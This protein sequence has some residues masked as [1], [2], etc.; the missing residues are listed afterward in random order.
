[1]VNSNAMTVRIAVI[2]ASALL[3]NCGNSDSPQESSSP[4][5][6][7]A[8]PTMQ[9]PGIEL[10]NGEHDFGTI[11]DL[12]PVSCTVP[13]TNIGSQPLVIRDLKAGCGCTKPVASK[14]IL[15]PGEQ[16]NIM[17]TFDPKGRSD[18][19]DKKVTIITN[20]ANAPE[21]EFWIRSFVN[22]YVK[23][24]RRQK[25]AQLGEMKR[26]AGKTLDVTFEPTA[27]D[28]E[29]ISMQPG[30]SHGRH[31][32][33]QEIAVKPGQPRRLR[34]TVSPD[35]P[36]GA[37]HS[38]LNVTGRGTLPDGTSGTYDFQILA[39]GHTYGTIRASQP[40]LSLGSVAPG[41]GYNKSIRIS[42]ADGEPFN[43][44]NAAVLQPPFDGMN[45]IPVP[46]ETALGSGYDLVLSGTAPDNIT[47][48][49]PFQA[50]A[51]VQTDVPDEEVL[52]FRVTGLVT[53]R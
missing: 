45:L 46:I 49:G 13:F 43:I 29:I 11:W 30:G 7:A 33:A 53:A 6:T 1:M 40:W 42:R 14:Q 32:S 3:V 22:N 34:I 31:I 19:Q 24:S 38:R 21:M 35:A 10:G 39:N 8:V 41:G 18:K 20:A 47:T 48:P 4:P 27:A 5:S 50:Q 52:K 44:V 16:G 51:M 25:F 15:Q 2:I 23:I 36:W 17:V 12:E 9:G 28:F 37:F 26:G